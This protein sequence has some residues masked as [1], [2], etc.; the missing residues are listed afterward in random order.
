[1]HPDKGGI[2]SDF[3][4]MSAAND[5][6]QN[7]VKNADLCKARETFLLEHDIVNKNFSSLSGIRTDTNQK[8]TIVRHKS[9]N[10]PEGHHGMCRMG[11][12]S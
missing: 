5:T 10:E 7:S 8:D 3:Q 6:W 11:I 2:L 1:M 9:G 12:A 4:R